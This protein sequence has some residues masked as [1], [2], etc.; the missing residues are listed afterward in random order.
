[1]GMQQYYSQAKNTAETVTELASLVETVMGQTG[2][3]S[4]SLTGLAKRTMVTSITY[5]ED[6]LVDNDIS[7]PLMGSLNQL[8]IG[9]V[10]T[11]LH[12]Y[13]SIDRYKVLENIVGRIAN[14]GLAI[15]DSKEL[16]DFI[17]TE[18]G[19][20]TTSTESYDNLKLLTIDESVK[21]LAVGRLIEFDFNIADGTRKDTEGN[22]I[23]ITERGDLSYGGNV[24]V[25]IYV[26]MFPVVMPSAT[27][28]A[29]ITLNFP[30]K[31]MR[32]WKMVK[33]GE[34]SFFKDFVLARDLVT[35]HGEAIKKDKNNVLGE[36]YKNKNKK[37]GKYIWNMIKKRKNNNL[38]SS[39]LIFSKDTF[40]TACDKAGLDF[41]KASD[42]QKFFNE[43]Y[44]IM[45]VVV[46][47]MYDMV[48]IYYN[49]ISN[50]TEVSFKAIKKAGDS[51]S[52]IDLAEMTKLI[53]M[54]SAPK[55]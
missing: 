24:I 14:E 9:Y 1:M 21:H 51:K 10:L 47:Q 36:F 26:Q 12:I 54:G 50:H 15:S 35:K 34:I 40:E 55:F 43:S 6:S 2:S 18:F 16:E 42:R 27:A 52:G 4:R 25:P 33:A 41:S 53:S 37:Q 22:K 23:N 46:D 38:A 20:A 13:N 28:D 5:I 19:K 29:I 39:T 49:G 7:I 17:T 30:T 48:D 44:A 3:S 11:A 8:Y 31:L 45:I 32:R